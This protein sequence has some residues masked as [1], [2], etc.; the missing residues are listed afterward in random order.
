[1]TRADIILKV[2]ARID[3]LSPF[4]S[5]ELNPSIELIDS[6]L[7]DSDTEIRRKV[8]VHLVD[9]AIF[10]ASSPI[11]NGDGTGY[12]PLPSDFL[13]LHSFK[14][15]EWAVTLNQPIS[16]SSPKY[17]LQK[18]TVTRGGVVKPVI[19]IRWGYDIPGGVIG[20][21]QNQVFIATASQT[22]FIVT[23]FTPNDEYL[24][25]LDGVLTTAGHIRTSN[26]IIFTPGLAEGTEVVIAN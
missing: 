14:M 26:V 23:E 3:E 21:L 16:E 24:V 12:I 17:P 10:D 11:D 20:S 4:S 7:D 2:K 25:Y 18:N 9:P 8:P 13:R 5:E 6:L 22:N 15:A 19:V 1:M